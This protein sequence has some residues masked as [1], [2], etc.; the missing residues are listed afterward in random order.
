MAQP[1]SPV[2]LS[3]GPILYH[4]PRDAILEFYERV[5]GLP[6]D[7]VYVGETVCSKRRSLRTGDWLDLAR[8][9][10]RAGKAV[11]LSTLAL[12]ESEAE[13]K[14]LR[15]L[16]E[17]GEFL[18][19][20]NDMGTVGLLAGRP[21]VG[22]TGINLYNPRAL[23]YLAA[24]GLRRWVLPLELGGEAFRAMQA[25]RPTGVE[26]EVFVYGRLPLA[27]SAR[28]FTA[29]AC[30]L[31]KDDCQYRCLDYPNGQLLRTQDNKSFL[32]INGI[33]T[34]SAATYNLLPVLEELTDRGVDIVRISPQASHTDRIVELFRRRLDGDLDLD[35]AKAGL[36]KLMPTGP[37]DGYWFGQPGMVAH[38]WRRASA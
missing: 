3:L 8:H 30:N 2:K 19:E 10:S 26:T 20:A 37:A 27:Y 6:V 18:I 38:A 14:T 13:L 33:Q 35:S 9:L 15:R 24:V 23:K 25:G 21:F 32:V 12:I 1:V 36:E 31:P 29:R 11:V 4:W 22:G 17:N 7:I 28:C 16:C 5:A 34:Q